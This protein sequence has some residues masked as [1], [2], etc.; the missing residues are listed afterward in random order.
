MPASV[1]KTILSGVWRR[2]GPWRMKKCK[3][4]VL[5]F[6]FEHE[7]DCSY[8][9]QK[10]PWL[11][12][13]VL[14]NI[15]PW[16]VEGK[17]RVGE[18]A[19]AKFWFQLWQ[20]GSL[21][22]NMPCSD[23]NG[24]SKDW[25]RGAN[26]TPPE[27]ELNGRN[28]RGLWKQRTVVKS[29]STTGGESTGIGE[30]TVV[31]KAP[32][33]SC[34]VKDKPNDDKE[35]RKL[36]FQLYKLDY[37]NLYKAQQSLLS[38]PPNL[39]EMITHLLGN[40]RKRKAHTWYQS[41][42]VNSCFSPPLC[43]ATEESNKENEAIPSSNGKFCIG[44]GDEGSSSKIENRERKPRGKEKLYSTRRSSRVKTRSGRKK[45]NMQLA[46][47]VAFVWLGERVSDAILRKF[48]KQVA[49]LRCS[50]M[51]VCLLGTSFVY[52]VTSMSFL[53][54]RKRRGVKALTEKKGSSLGIFFSI[55]GV[56]LGC[57]GGFVTWKN[58]RNT[59]N[60]IHKQLDRVVVDANWCTEYLKARVVKFP[61]VGSDHALI[62]LQVMGEVNKLKYLFRFLKVWTS[63]P[64]CG[65]IIKNSR[66]KS[67]NGSSAAKLLGKLKGIKYDLKKWNQEVFGFSDRRLMEL[68]RKLIGIQEGQ[69][70]KE[71]AD[72]LTKYLP[73]MP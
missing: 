37:L 23:D 33:L 46:L 4:G 9:L 14:L 35:A 30:K 11:V 52:M 65:K 67:I 41:F 39:S 43:P 60:Q 72:L 56:D 50:F 61:I 18:F 6:F 71:W 8:V 17:V 44:V 40:N 36:F 19:V 32:A 34:H 16:P 47:L 25:G 3:N 54:L 2:L 28:R 12:N 38:N 7:D 49:V 20:V 22:Q 57:E 68:P 58:L 1:V 13:G 31:V 5:G 26:G 51:G 10:R 55:R 42:L 64:D 48:S 66:M 24:H 45:Y 21:G 73:E 15:K 53:M 63:Q 69:Q 29:R 59:H 70:A 27:W 62:C